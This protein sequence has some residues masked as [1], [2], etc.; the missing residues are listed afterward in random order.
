[1]G[2]AHKEPVWGRHGRIH[3]NTVMDK[4]YVE[5]HF[6]YLRQGG[7]AF[8]EDFCWFDNWQ[9]YTKFTELISIELC[10]GFGAWPHSILVGIWINGLIQ[11]VRVLCL[12]WG[13]CS[14]ST[15]QMFSNVSS[16]TL[17]IDVD[18]SSNPVL[19]VGQTAH[20]SHWHRGISRKCQPVDHCE[21]R[22]QYTF[23]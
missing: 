9:D 22:K 16:R 18:K 14:P 13:M 4:L 10:W 17:T 2:P 20:F 23:S 3:S 5:S 19:V 1:M 21:K 15:L 12:G 6:K 7:Y 11:G 8:M